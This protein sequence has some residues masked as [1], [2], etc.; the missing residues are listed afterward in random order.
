MS[1]GFFQFVCIPRGGLPGQS[2]LRNA[3]E[4]VLH[5]LDAQEESHVQRI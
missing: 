1:A 4:E 3:G 2:V 5:G